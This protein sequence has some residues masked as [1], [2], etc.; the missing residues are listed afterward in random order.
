M[1][2]KQ[3]FL[4]FFCLLSLS[5]MGRA[6]PVIQDGETSMTREEVEYLVRQ[7]T[8]EMQRSAASD[9]GDRIELLSGALVTKKMAA[10]ADA[11]ADSVDRDSYWKYQMA[12]RRVKSKFVLD[13]FL[14]TLEVPD[15]TELAAERYISEKDRYALVPE[16]R[17]SSHILLQCLPGRCDRAEKRPEAQKILAELR[18]GADFGEMV[19]Q[20]S[21]D[22]GTKQ[23]GGKFDKWIRKGEP[24]VEP[25][26][27]GGLFSIEKVGDYS[28]VVETKYGLHIIR[29]DEIRTSHYRTLE[30]VR[31]AIIASLEQEYRKLAV[32]EFGGRYR[33]SNDARLD[34]AALDK[35]FAPYREEPA[36]AASESP[37]GEASAN[38]DTP[39]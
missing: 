4:V 35:I 17:R 23:R 18:A 26:Y 9:P 21:D 24:Q 25:H 2:F 39:E 29:L 8:P 22:P 33:L 37:T 5:G 1:I 31:P 27:V 14:E 15:M 11:L 19:Q 34:E 16:Q 3:R 7:W 13:H 20:Y 10:E 30:E 32:K 12:L 28:D 6:Q 38:A 36:E